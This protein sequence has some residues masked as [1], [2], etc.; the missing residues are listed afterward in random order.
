LLEQPEQIEHTGLEYK[1][2]LDIQQ[3]LC[4]SMQHQL[5]WLLHAELRFVENCIIENPKYASDK[6]QTELFPETTV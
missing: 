4:T 1:K 3:K 6:I 5:Q 2:L